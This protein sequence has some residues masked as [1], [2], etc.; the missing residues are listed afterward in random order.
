MNDQE[1]VLPAHVQAI[2]D[3]LSASV[4]GPVDPETG[5]Y[6]LKNNGQH[7]RYEERMRAWWGLEPRTPTRQRGRRCPAQHCVTAVIPRVRCVADDKRCGCPGPCRR[8]DVPGWVAEH[9][10]QCMCQQLFLNYDHT[11]L[12]TDPETNGTVW[13]TEPYGEPGDV[14]ASRKVLEEHGLEL[15]VSSR[16]PWYPTFTTLLMV[17]KA[18]DRL[19]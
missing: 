11:H 3:A 19:H 9:K 12:W 2:Q 16:S 7:R 15:T 6:S 10:P 1:K 13:T 4:S 8:S 5:Q 18:A 14:T 17:R